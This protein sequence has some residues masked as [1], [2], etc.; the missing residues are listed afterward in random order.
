MPQ[1]P[2]V[3][4]TELKPETVKVDDLVRFPEMTSWFAPGLLA[5]LLMRVIV[6]DVFGQYADRR[7]TEAAL[8][9][10]WRDEL[11]DRIDLKLTPDRDGAVWLDYVSDLGDGFDPTYAIAYLLAQPRIT[12]GGETLPRGNVLVTGPRW[13]VRLQC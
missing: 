13:V 12:A 9:P 11:S 10:H 3:P 4:L 8:D 7:L 2:K 1:T 6:S 5:K